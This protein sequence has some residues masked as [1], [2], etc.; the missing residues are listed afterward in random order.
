MEKLKNFLLDLLF[1]THCI[2]CKIKGPELCQDCCNDIPYPDSENME[3]IFASFQY[4]DPTI[5]K[6]LHSLKYYNKKHI[7]I[8]MG[9]YLY[10]RMAEEI[11]E[12]YTFSSGAPIL[13]LPVPLSSQRQKERGYNQADLIARGLIQNDI[14]KIFVLENNIL[15]KTKNTLPQAR[16][17]NRNTRLKNIIGCFEIKNREKIKGKTIIV[18]DD[19]TT[20]GG[21][22]YEIMKVL[23]KNGAKK[24]VGF[25]VAH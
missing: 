6:L 24:I 13:L 7:G 15:I 9:S 23:K 3:N 5:K 12:L 17:K 20:T 21:T 18:L 10:E 16:I 2:K 22:I 11:S 19:V 14:N 8:L 25:A 1:P 4:Q